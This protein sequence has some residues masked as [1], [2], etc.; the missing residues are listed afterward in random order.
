[1]RGDFIRWDWIGGHLDE[2][3]ARLL[4]HVQLTVIA[5]VVGFAIALPLGIYAFRHRR[6]R[7]PFAGFTSVLYTIP[8]VALFAFLQPF[9]GL[10][11]LT[12]EIGLVAYT[13]VILVRNVVAG[14][15]GVPHDIREAARGMGLSERQLLWRVDLPVALPVL[16]A[17]IRLATVST[18]ALVT[19]TTLIGKGGMGYFI[20][21]IGIRRSFP[22]ALIVGAVLS[23]ALALTA[24]GLLLWAQRR[25]TPW[26]GAR[27]S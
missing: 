22:T 21:Q 3:G 7:G 25:A 5:V 19:V 13:L 1:M 24:D 17:G 6:A 11:T 9:S 14:L 12:A 10:S 27:A 8:S 26:A 20:L 16:M 15:D 23:V 18:V 4:E 2:I